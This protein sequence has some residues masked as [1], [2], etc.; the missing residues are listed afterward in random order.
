MDGFGVNSVAVKACLM[1]QQRDFCSDALCDACISLSERMFQ[2]V[3]DATS[4]MTLH[5]LPFAGLGCL[6]AIHVSP[7]CGMPVGCLRAHRGFTL[8]Y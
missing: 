8:Q 2:N 1:L 6:S 7:L 4:G 5:G 3:E